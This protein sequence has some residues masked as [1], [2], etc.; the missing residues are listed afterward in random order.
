MGRHRRRRRPV[1]QLVLVVFVPAALTA[2]L[3]VT[4]A[5]SVAVDDIPR[6]FLGHR[7]PST[8]TNPSADKPQSKMWNTD[9]SWW[10]LMVPAS[11]SETRIF[12]LNEATHV[13]QDT[14]TVVD[15][16]LNST[17]D[18]LWKEGAQELTVVSRYA[19]TNPRVTRFRY[20]AATGAYTRQT[21]FPVTVSTGGGS[22][23]AVIDQDSTG[24][25]WIT[26]TRSGRLWV[27]HSDPS[28]LVWTAGYNP[29]VG[30]Y[31][32][33]SDD[34]SALV[35]FDDSIGVMWSDQGADAFR[36]AIHHDGAAD[37]V[38]SVE[39]ALQG[40]SMADD[41]INL[42]AAHGHVYAAIKT[43]EGDSVND[44]S[45][46]PLVGVLARTPGQGDAGTWQFLVAGT[47]A[48]QHTRPLVMVDETNEHLYFIAT[49]V[50]N[51][52]IY[53]KRTDLAAPDFTNQPGR[54]TKL[55]D[56]VAQLNN[57]TGS[58]Q[59]ITHA[60]G[61]V[62]LAASPAQDTYAYAEMELAPGGPPDTQA[63]TAPQNVAA[64][65]DVG[66]VDLSW[67]ASADD[68]GVVSYVVR[69]DGVALPPTE[70]TS[71]TDLA[72][73]PGV[74]YSYTVAATDAA[75]NESA[76]SGSVVAN[77]PPNPPGTGISLRAATTAANNDTRTLTLPV[78]IS[79]AGDL[80]LVSVTTRNQPVIAPP[81]GWH[82]ERRDVSGTAVQQALYWRFAT[83]SEPTSYTWNLSLARGAV[84]TMLAYS[85]VSASTPVATSAAQVASS[86]SI[87]SPSVTIGSPGAML[88][89]FYAIAKL[90]TIAEPS[91]M[92]ELTEVGSPST[93]DYPVTNESSHEVR[94]V[95]GPSGVRVASSTQSGPNIGQVIVLNRS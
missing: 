91:G 16:I 70:Q 20:D 5:P 54:G 67:D 3:V 77:V 42:K 60:T 41:H 66:R 62:I 27:A 48:E 49:A 17:S 2:S 12:R 24:R 53:Y 79:S 26:Y 86:K 80:L 61:L 9:G 71:Y 51:G 85:G 88:V 75:G 46:A 73:A 28:G 83:S 18:A 1:T 89:G 29:A 47:V 25:L 81:A 68:I 14:G 44:P 65:A 34:I 87:T 90:S 19:S 36:F 92:S 59:P 33:T 82:L 23:S 84:G 69:R 93:V 94:G 63:P 10:A 52:N 39:T 32:I 31:T 56:T 45:T 43:S 30:D 15:S 95:A 58:K 37:Q 13:W 40:D 50:G 64:E 57:A 76:E 78:P 8:V 22:E 55:V 4:P 74:T 11:S 6:T 35:A 21:G 38:W 7:H 72:V